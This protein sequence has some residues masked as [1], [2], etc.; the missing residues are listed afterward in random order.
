MGSPTDKPIHTKGGIY[1]YQAPLPNKKTLVIKSEEAKRNIF[2]ISVIKLLLSVGFNNE[3]VVA[4]FRGD[5]S[6]ESFT[7]LQNYEDKS[8]VFFRNIMIKEFNI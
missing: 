4:N 2:E 3:N 5:K 8:K 1:N 7:G 6:L